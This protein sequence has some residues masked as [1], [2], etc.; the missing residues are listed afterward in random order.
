MFFFFQAEDGI[1]DLTVTGVQTCALPIYVREIADAFPPYWPTLVSAVGGRFASVFDLFV[2]R[3]GYDEWYAYDF[4]ALATLVT[5]EYAGTVEAF[6]SNVTT[7]VFGEGIIA[8]GV[9]GFLAMSALA[10]LVIAVNRLAL[11]SAAKRRRPLLAIVAANF[12]G[13]SAWSWLDSGGITSLLNLPHVIS[14]LVTALLAS[15]LLFM[16]RIPWGRREATIVETRTISES[17]R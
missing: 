6:R 3:E 2:R 11:S 15:W 16:S 17:S 7:T 13:F 9:P 14:Y 1:R 8:L 12:F 5:K 4:S 10:G